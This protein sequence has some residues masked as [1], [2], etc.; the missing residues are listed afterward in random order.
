MVLIGYLT[1][2]QMLVPELMVSFLVPLQIHWSNND[3]R[4]FDYTC[5]VRVY[6]GRGSGQVRTKMDKGREQRAGQE[7]SP[8]RVGDRLDSM[9][10]DNKR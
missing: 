7:V 2:Q 6:S 3:N 5:Q 10:K 9:T 8:A 1:T 4:S